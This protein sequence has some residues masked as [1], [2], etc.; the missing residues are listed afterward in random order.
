MKYSLRA[1]FAYQKKKKK[2]SNTNWNI[3]KAICLKVFSDVVCGQTVLCCKFTLHRS[4]SDILAF[5]LLKLCYIYCIFFSQSLHECV[6]KVPRR[7]LHPK[8]TRTTVVQFFSVNSREIS[9][10]YFHLHTRLFFLHRV[11]H[12]SRKN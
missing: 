5:I 4:Q 3:F 1:P 7:K 2:R 9:F 11:R 10:L 12:F 8:L 6:A